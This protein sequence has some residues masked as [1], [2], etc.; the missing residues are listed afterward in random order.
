MLV[1]AA[2]VLAQAARS[3]IVQARPGPR[4]AG[5]VVLAGSVL[6]LPAPGYLT[7]RLATQWR[8]R[9][10]PGDG[11]SPGSL[12]RYLA[13]GTKRLSHAGRVE[14]ALDRLVINTARTYC[15]PIASGAESV[16]LGHRAPSS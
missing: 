2:C 3:L 1:A 13:S 7:L 14:Q 15:G 6:V 16:A 5:L 4:G 8:G 12:S 10:L 9:A 11:A